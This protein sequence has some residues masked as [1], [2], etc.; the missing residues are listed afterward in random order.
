[1]CARARI[2]I[3]IYYTHKYT[4]TLVYTR[5]RIKYIIYG[6]GVRS[7]IDIYRGGTYN[8]KYNIIV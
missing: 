5:N 4:N 1:V 6:R 7:R 2:Y 8:V 3:Y